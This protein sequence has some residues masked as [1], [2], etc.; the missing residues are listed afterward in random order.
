MKKNVIDNDGCVALVGAIIR[1]AVL[2]DPYWLLHPNARFWFMV[3]NLHNVKKVYET[4]LAQPANDHLE[5]FPYVA[6]SV[7]EHKNFLKDIDPEKRQGR[8]LKQ[9][10]PYRIKL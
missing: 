10:S 7:K 9:R 8:R 2:H 6:L 5:K 4:A 3:G 1:D